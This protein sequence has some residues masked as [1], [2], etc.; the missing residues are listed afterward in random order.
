MRPTLLNPA[1]LLSLLLSSLVCAGCGSDDDD[2]SASGDDDDSAAAFAPSYEFESRFKTGESSVSNGGQMFRQVLISNIKSY[3][4]DLTGKLD[5]PTNPLDPALIA[6]QLNSYYAWNGDLLANEHGISAT[7]AASQIYFS[8]IHESGKSLSGKIAGADSGQHVDWSTALAGWNAT[9]SVSPEGLVQA[10]FNELQAQAVDWSNGTYPLDPA[11]A[12]VSEVYK[13]AAGHD[14]QQLLHKF[15]MGAVSFSQAADDYLD[16][17]LTK[18]NTAAADIGKAYSD[19]E[20]AWD[21]GFGY[22]GASRNNDAYSDDEIKASW[23]NDE[24]SDGAIDLKMECNWGH[25]VNAA[26]RDVGSASGTATTDFSAGAFD[27]FLAGR[28]LI[29]TA[30]GALSATQMTELEG[31]R[32]TAISNWEMAIASTVVHYINDV[33]GDIEEF[34][35]TGYN[36]DDHSNHWSEL[37]GFALSLQ[38]NP[39]SPLSDTDFEA[40][41]GHIGMAPVLPTATA[42]EI[43]AYETALNDAKGI[44]ATAYGFDAGN[45]A[46]W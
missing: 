26:K 23:C 6:S 18:D 32:T 8:D 2:D 37:K 42:A 27:A 46:A 11:G 20:H 28:S 9:G 43:T 16:E 3:V 22:Y 41:H 40:L 14:L 12:P 30:D 7:P 25:S 15:M 1:L 17:G 4:G 44:L 29:H 10:W 24:N 39:Y 21:E 45:V 35:T 5:D 19:L 31:Y 34:G 33:L 36:F 38:F 13:T